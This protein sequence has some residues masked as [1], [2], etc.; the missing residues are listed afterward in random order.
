[1]QD[2]ELVKVHHPDSPLCHDVPPTIRHARFQAI[3]N[4][5]DVLKGK[6]GAHLHDPAMEELERRR[7]SMAHRPRPR[8]DFPGHRAPDIDWNAGVDDRWKDWVI[9]ASGVLVRCT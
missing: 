9:I 3:T 7:R 8:T 6:H 1:M 4:A 2:Y 5:Y